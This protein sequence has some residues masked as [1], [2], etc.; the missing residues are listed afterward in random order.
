MDIKRVRVSVEVSTGNVRHTAEIG[1]EESL[2][3]ALQAWTKQSIREV[4]PNGRM[5]SQE[6][7]AS[8]IARSTG[9]GVDHIVYTSEIVVDYEADPGPDCSSGDGFSLF[10]GEPDRHSDLDRV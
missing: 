2:I 10:H 7:I 8:K 6:E 4:C 9:S 1:E 3:V 5:G